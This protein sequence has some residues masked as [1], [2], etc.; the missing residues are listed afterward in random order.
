M[1]KGAGLFFWTV[2]VGIVCFPTSPV[3]GCVAPSS[4]TFSAVSATGMT[5]DWFSFCS[6]ATVQYSQVDDDPAFLS[7]FTL[8]SF[9]P[10][11][12]FGS[13]VPLI[14]NTVYYAQVST[15]P[16]MVGSVSLGS[17]RTLANLPVALLP[18][19][20][21]S[22]QLQC[23]WLA[24]GN[25][26]G[27]LY[28][29]EISSDSFASV[30]SASSTVG[31][32]MLWNSLQPNTLYSFHVRVGSGGSF[33]ALG[34]TPT[35]AEV[36]GV[37]SIPFSNISIQGFR[38][39]WTSGTVQWNPPDT[40]Y[41][42]EVSTSAI[43]S[44][45]VTTLSTTNLYVDF[46][47][48]SEGT[49]YYAHVRAVNR[50]GIL[51][52]F[53]D[54]GSTR[55]AVTPFNTGGS[56]AT[57][58]SPDGA[59][60]VTVASGT[61]A[62][63]YRL[64]LSTDPIGFPLGPPDLPAKIN[65]AEDKLVEGGEVSQ[66]PIPNVI[67]EIRAEDVHGNM[68]DSQA[69]HSLTVT[70]VYPSS[71]GETV[72]LGGG[73]IVRAHTLAIY[74]LNEEKSLWVRVPT[75]QVDSSARKV[76]AAVPG[77]GVFSLVG[78]TDTSLETAYAYPVPFLEKRGDKTITFSDLAQKATVR[79]FSASGRWVQT[80]E[81]TDGDGELVWDVRDVDGDPLPSGVYFYLLESS[82]D[83]KRG[84]LVIVRGSHAP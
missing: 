4:T 30:L 34:S 15:S 2:L 35:F 65:L 62:E 71:D 5:V 46:S 10:P 54:L 52:A 6:T 43:F 53:A 55:T 80:L 56:S 16:S 48:L 60:V 73:P 20:I 1:K 13:T 59:V 18:S 8:N 37:P 58:Q 81:E 70:F 31:T 75:S 24:N 23:D 12:V 39:G 19:V 7:P 68:I 82:A 41:Q 42:A 38:V 26:G 67:S 49:T 45:G 69:P 40:S 22:T 64:S 25:P 78:Q 27:T 61:F 44:G 76:S 21:S 77:L 3:L 79:I 11:G 84:K 57:I 33:T 17:T 63:D 47:G 29:S 51:T 72:T 32:T 28:Q 9:G 50:A 74:R 14:P 83:K 36:P 66:T